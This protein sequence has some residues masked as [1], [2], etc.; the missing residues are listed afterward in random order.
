MTT[1]VWKVEAVIN[2]CPD[3][4]LPVNIWTTGETLN[5]SWYLALFCVR[6]WEIAAPAKPN[7]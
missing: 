2:I 1:R 5:A 3:K 4:E 7:V 6:I